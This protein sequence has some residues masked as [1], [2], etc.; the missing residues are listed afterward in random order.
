MQET[1]DHFHRH[2]EALIGKRD[3]AAALACLTGGLS[4]HRT[5]HDTLLWLGVLGLHAQRPALAQAALSERLLSE[6]KAQAVSLIAR[7][8]TGSAAHAYWQEAYR[9]EPTNTL[10]LTAY[11]TSLQHNAA[12][13]GQPCKQSSQKRSQQRSQQQ[14]QQ[15]LKRHANPVA[16]VQAAATLAPFFAHGLG[17]PC[18]GVWQHGNRLKGWYLAHADSA[19]PTFTL[20]A[21]NQ[22]ATV[23]PALTSQ[24]AATPDLPAMRLYWLDSALKG[25]AEGTP[26]QVEANGTALLGSPLNWQ[27]T[28]PPTL[29]ASKR[30]S[31][32][33]V[34]LVPVYKGHA[35]TIACLESVLASQAENTT[36]FRLV[37]VN[38]ASP[39]NELVNA[40]QQLATNGHI[41]LHHQAHN[42]GFIG[43]VNNGLRQCAGSNV[44]LLNADTLVHGN[45]VDR[46]HTAAY[47]HPNVASVTPLSNNGELMSLLAPCEPAA[48]LTPAQLAQL[49][50]AAAKANGHA[51]EQDVE[52]DT[53][54]G[55][56]L[57]LRSD[58]L[59]EQGGLD[60]TLTR[61]YGEESDW[62][63]R[64]HRHGRHHR[65][66]LDV[67][68]AHQGGVSFGDE[69]RLRVKQNLAVLEQ[70]YPHAEQRFNACL[71]TDPMQQGR[72]RLIRQW[73]RNQPLATF[74]PN[75]LT[76]VPLWPSVAQAER[77]LR[78][79]S[80]D[81]ALA[82][83]GQRQLTL[84]G[85]QPHAWRLAYR[86]PEQR[87]DLAADLHALGVTSAMP[88]TYALSHW[89]TATLPAMAQAP[90]TA[91]LLANHALVTNHAPSTKHAPATANQAQANVVLPSHGALIAVAGQSESLQ[92]PALAEL[93][94]ALAKQQQATYLLLLNPP[95][96]MASALVSSGHVFSL[97][98]A[99]S[100][101]KERVALCHAHLPLS[102]VLLLDTQPATLADAHWLT[103]QQPL[104]WL[105]PEHLAT[106]ATW[107][108][109]PEGV[110]RLT[111]LLSLA[112]RP[113]QP[114]ART[115]PSKA[116]GIQA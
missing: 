105:V 3:Y 60:P 95:G 62:C 65:G 26:L 115:A 2:V 55:F 38:D 50:N 106:E 84:C 57:Y 58:A 17:L 100:R 71:T 87:T 82:R 99:T 39:D 93:A 13:Q 11:L 75:G 96:Q 86:L 94:N 67:V 35:E 29:P 41:E 4:D 16:D 77:S 46:L 37:V 33:V 73:L 103:E 61:G 44:I 20:N 85:S 54:C 80:S 59:A 40:L 49:D 113:R 43:T 107:L 72:Y 52:I 112:T 108:A 1:F 9:S 104:P 78:A 19:A 81:I 64:A 27:P 36:P 34:V 22:R 70:R 10:T 98:L 92:Q 109:N 21:G 111:S 114:N 25:M 102:A 31:H 69:K 18:G 74:R 110:I 66:A 88:T 56:C 68:V 6:P 14:Y 42:Q 51:G 101:W 91:T 116:S 89:L 97:P 5:H 45:W 8:L 23:A 15:L 53:G 83:S 12:G 90:V 28:A 24:L 30:S 76:S 79:P 63:Y 7:T 32:R 48:A 47:R